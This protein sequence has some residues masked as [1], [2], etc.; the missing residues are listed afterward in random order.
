MALALALA[1][2]ATCEAPFRF[3]VGGMAVSVTTLG[4]DHDPD[5]YVVLVDGDS[6]GAVGP[7]GALTIDA[8]DV[9]EHSVDLAGVARNCALSGGRRS[10]RVIEDSVAAVAL[11]VACNPLT[12]RVR[13]AVTTTGA[14][15]DANGYRVM[16]G[17]AALFVPRSGVAT[18]TAIREGSHVV[19]VDDVAPNCV[20]ASPVPNPVTVA[21]DS[22]SD[23]AIAVSC[24][25][26]T[27]AVRVTATTTGP[28]PDGNGYQVLIDGATVAGI[29][30]NG[31]RIVPS[32]LGG[33]HS[34]ELR[35]VAVN[36]APFPVAPVTVDVPVADTV[37]VAFAVTCQA[38][39]VINVAT[40]T[41]GGSPDPNGYQ[42]KVDSASP[43]P[44][45]VNG[46]VGIAVAAGVHTVEL[47]DV[48]TNCLVTSANPDSVTVTWG[49]T[50]GLAFAVS[51]PS[52]GAVAVSVA[53][54]GVELD[55][56]GYWVAAERPGFVGGAAA[57]VNGTVVL[58]G[59]APGNY[60]V[61]LSGAATNC[62]VATANPDTV[63][64]VGGD[65][66]AIAF[67]VICVVTSGTLLITTETTGSPADP[68]GYRVVVDESC[69]YY[70]CWW[71]WEG[72]LAVNDTAA[73]PS[74][75]GSHTVGISGIAANCFLTGS[76]W[77]TATVPP[78]DT[79]TVAFAVTCAPTGSVEVIVT[80]AGADVDP[81]GYALSL[82]R[83]GFWISD[84]SA[85]NDTILFTGLSATDHQL[86]LYQATPNC[87]VT[88]APNPRT[89]T[90]VSD[91]TVRVMFDITC[92]A[93]GAVAVSV[94]TTG[95]DF[96]PDGYRLGLTGPGF[97][98]D[99]LVVANGSVTFSRLLPGDYMLELTGA[100]MN[101]APGGSNPQ[102]VT[103][104]GGATASVSI[105]VACT[106]ATRIAFTRDEGGNADI[107][108]IL[109]NGTGL[110]R[111]TTQAAFD[112]EAAWSP[113]GAKIAFVSRRDGPTPE[114]YVMNADGS[115]ATRLTMNAAADWAPAWSPDGA[116]IAF[117]SNRDGNA[118]IHVMNADG[119][120]PVRL[121]SNT[122]VDD[123]PVWSPDGS[124]IAFVSTRDGNAEIYAMN[125]DGSS[126][127]RLT[128]N[129][130]AD[131]SPDWSPSGRIALHRETGCGYYYCDYDVIVM[132]ADGS[133]A[134]MLQSFAVESEPAWSPD[135]QW[136]AVTRTYCDDY[137]GCS[138]PSIVLRRLDGTSV[139]LVANGFEPA[140]RR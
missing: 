38:F 11:G 62:A 69:D 89:V 111:L 135:G 107:Y 98:T 130:V 27:G 81:D 29:A 44:I 113:D 102:P 68:D 57:P 15:L 13:V 138:F 45:A 77:R 26:I 64:V 127:Q 95:V 119:S 67:A 32:L 6:S 100:T 112:G 2:G 56:D 7:N 25:A 78:G 110:T 58:P 8:L 3:Q 17:T 137:Y 87:A 70:Y 35:D 43:R 75:A 36:C 114:I 132:N 50:V 12:G 63:T 96:D 123:E 105:A 116:K 54:T 18:F 121:T 91:D 16:I 61:T 80:T 103:V 134:T 72:T 4:T 51:C 1:A 20:A 104:V 65:T 79:A 115:G 109:T 40:S 88:G 47:R 41:T 52:P 74:G 106:A 19:T 14:D 118:E 101:C 129:G 59:L 22:T 99:S 128:V 24:G 117:T 39:A 133:G 126:P 125:A 10:V 46:A 108:T 76:Q 42:V 31:T 49:D 55:Q 83:P 60:V 97:F 85:V 90:V 28:D 93:L 92:E 21:Y 5:G 136:I 23:L 84:S 124:R 122:V 48:A 131:G 120:S 37:D 139:E 33:T 30:S 94:T 86:A 34:V 71:L 9:G 66:V 82:S 73:I 53:T 140:W